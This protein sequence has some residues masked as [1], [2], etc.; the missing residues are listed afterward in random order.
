MTKSILRKIVL[1]MLLAAMAVAMGCATTT[2]TVAPTGNIS[3]LRSFYVSK[4]PADHHGIDV[5]LA[6]QLKS[7]GYVASAGSSS[8]VPQGT[9]A[10]LTYQ[11]SWKWDITMYLIRLHV[12]VRDPAN[13]AVLALGQAYRPSLQRSSP[14]ELVKEVLESIFNNSMTVEEHALLGA[15]Y[16]GRAA[17]TGNSFSS[18]LRVREKK[19]LHDQEAW[20]ALALDTL[21]TSTDKNIGWYYLG[22]AAEGLGYYTA[23]LAYY[24]KSVDHSSGSSTSCLSA[25]TCSGFTFPDA[26]LERIEKLKKAMTAE[27]EH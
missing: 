2:T 5:L 22:R 8:S 15:F 14:D 24:Q 10:I 7:M 12:Q 17:I 11:D 6:K 4:L 1:P 21:K 27:P 16:E 3:S 13:N 23:A 18:A 9:D 25:A 26:P 20:I 19:A